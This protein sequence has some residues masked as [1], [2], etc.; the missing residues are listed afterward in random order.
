M[1]TISKKH[2]AD[3][4]I[5]MAG[6]ILGILFVALCGYMG[7]Q[8]EDISQTYDSQPHPAQTTTDTPPMPK[9][10]NVKHVDIQGAPEVDTGG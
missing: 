3:I 8:Q 4:E 1:I 2:D 9:D 10:T 5:I 6:L 7:S